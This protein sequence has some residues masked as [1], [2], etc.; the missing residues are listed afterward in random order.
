MAVSFYSEPLGD[1]YLLNMYFL[2]IFLR[3]AKVT[4]FHFP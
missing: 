4:L 3:I 2:Y 1:R